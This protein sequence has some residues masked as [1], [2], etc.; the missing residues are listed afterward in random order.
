MLT[1]SLTEPIISID[2]QLGID[3][4]HSWTISFITANDSYEIGSEVRIYRDGVLLI[5]GAVTS[6][7]YDVKTKVMTISGSDQTSFADQYDRQEAELAT[8]S[9]T[10]VRAA[11]EAVQAGSVLD[12]PTITCFGFGAYNGDTQSF[13][14]RVSNS[15]GLNWYV[16]P[17][18]AG[19]TLSSGDIVTPASPQLYQGFD[20]TSGNDYDER[21]SRIYVQ[22]AIT[23]D[24]KNKLTIKNPPTS[25]TQMVRLK[26][27]N[28][29]ETQ[30]GAQFPM[31]YWID[32]WHKC[33]C[34]IDVPAGNT[35]YNQAASI[36]AVKQLKVVSCSD[37]TH[38]PAWHLELW[39]ANPGVGTTN[40]NKLAT[41]SVGQTWTASGNQTATYARIAATVMQNGVGIT[42]YP[43][44]DGV[45][46][47]AYAWAEIP[48]SAVEAWSDTF[49]SGDVGRPDYNIINEEMFPNHDS[50]V[51]QGLGRQIARRDS[52]VNRKSITIPGNPLIGIKS[53]YKMV[54]DGSDVVLPATSI[55]YVN[56]LGAEQA[57]I[58][59]EW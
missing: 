27:P 14:D 45:E 29:I 15:F 39:D 20:Y 22:K 30:S 54:I 48:G 57:Q 24:Q 17:I 19:Y 49:E 28:A 56:A 6:Y 31:D 46:M 37:S 38:T 53:G 2:V 50:F 21:I 34:T 36:G 43:H 52:I 13:V 11:V 51:S 41:L 8:D 18:G 35:V 5:I 7:S 10:T 44:Y 23:T 16:N 47:E 55:H 9:L 4:A 58:A 12:C 59:G 32:P 1:A 25:S 42:D 40:A 3:N 26:N 33:F